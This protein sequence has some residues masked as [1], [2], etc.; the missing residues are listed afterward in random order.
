MFNCDPFSDFSLSDFHRDAPFNQPIVTPQFDSALKYVYNFDR[1]G[2]NRS[3][4]LAG[5]LFLFENIVRFGHRIVEKQ[6]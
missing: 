6:D 2:P 3:S 5:A 4:T 1:S